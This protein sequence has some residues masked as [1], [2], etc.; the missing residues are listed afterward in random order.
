MLRKRHSGYRV[1]GLLAALLILLARGP[2]APAQEAKTAPAKEAKAALAAPAESGGPRKGL[3]IAAVQLQIRASDLRSYADFRFHMESLVRRC[4]V[5]QP[6]LIVFPEYTSV[7]LSLVPYYSEIGASISAA[8]GIER[9]RVREPLIEDF[10][11]LFLLNSGLAKEAM[12]GI[13]GGLARSYGVGVLAGSY[14]ALREEG[15]EARLVNRTV[16]FDRDGQSTYAQDKVFLTPFEKDLLGM[17]PG[18]IDEAKPIGLDGYRI[19]VTLCRDTFFSAWQEVYAGADL[20][21]DLKAN[22]TVFD[23]EERERF[24]R[25]VPARISEGDVPFGLTV[26]L[27]GSLLDLLWEGESSLV[28]KDGARGVRFL[29]RASS[30]RREEILFFTI[31]PRD[32]GGPGERP[33]GEAPRHESGGRGEYPHA[34]PPD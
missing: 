15:G 29:K 31:G 4:M 5:S 18:S 14:F 34:A 21:I 26:C 2:D 11:D 30:V 7:F 3:R 16:L 27:T 24:L 25:A 17:S 19:A 32:R 1:A 33:S 10:R 6:D 12:E 22:G 8:E 20:W 9:I 13:F 23:Q 28:R